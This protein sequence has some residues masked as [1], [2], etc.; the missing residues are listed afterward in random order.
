MILEMRIPKRIITIPVI[1]VVA[2]AALGIAARWHLVQSN[3]AYCSMQLRNYNTG[4]ASCGIDLSCSEAWKDPAKTEALVWKLFEMRV[5]TCPSG[6]TCSIVYNRGII[7][8][9]PHLVC[10]METSHGHIDPNIAFDERQIAE[11]ARMGSAIE[12]VEA[13][14]T[15]I[16]SRIERL[17]ARHPQL[18][19]FSAAAC[20]HET[21]TQA[22]MEPGS[23]GNPELFSISYANGII[24]M[25][26]AAEPEQGMGRKRPA[27]D[28]FDPTHGIRL[29]V[30]FFNGDA[31]GADARWPEKIGMLSVHLYVTGPATEAIRREIEKEIRR[32]K[33]DYRY[34]LPPIPQSEK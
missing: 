12:N 4:I 32:L 14:A 9:Q 23:P 22:G 7:R 20:L 30:H 3:N 15:R 1:A 11:R 17:K 28:R 16:A 27:Q 18:E 26:P 24:P 25:T 21:P 19:H 8:S 2:L 31:R 34:D 6:G 10:S 13:I 29:D 5:P 33:D